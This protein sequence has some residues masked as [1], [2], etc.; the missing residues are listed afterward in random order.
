MVEK[1]LNNSGEAQKSISVVIPVYNSASTVADAI[2]CLLSQ[3]Y[4]NLEIICVNDGSSDN[5][6]EILER[7]A[8]SHSFIRV[9]NQENSGVSAARNLGLTNAKGDIVTFLDADDVY[10]PHALGR[11]AQ[12]FSQPGVEVFTFGFYCHPQ[13]ATPLGLEKA[14]KPDDKTYIQFDSA[15]LFKDNARPYIGRSAFSRQFLLRESI[16][17]EPGITLGEDQVIYFLAYPLAKKTVLSSEQ[18]YQYNMRQDSAT[19]TNANDSN[20][21][22]YRLNQHLKVVETILREWKAR[23]LETQCRNELLEWIADFVLFD[24]NR[25]QAQKRQQLFQRLL[26]SLKDYYGGNPSQVARSLALQKCFYDIEPLTTNQ[27]T[28]NRKVK[29]PHLGLFY[30][31]RYGL[32]RCVQQA[33]IMCGILKKWH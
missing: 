21:D 11:I 25:L 7:Y 19:H 32:I 28:R 15:L 23:G 16:K 20:G 30:L 6:L 4:N 18:L 29:L 27:K 1:L 22:E 31:S 33:L 13:S 26:K 3:R 8:Q 10:A 2:N 12:A 17:F 5:S 9:L 14:L 24:I